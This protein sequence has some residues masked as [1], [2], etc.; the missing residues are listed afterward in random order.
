[1]R[2]DNI[3]TVL[4]KNATIDYLA[5]LELKG[6]SYIVVD[7][8][9]DLR[10]ILT[11]IKR[12]FNVKTISLQGGG[13]IDGAMLAQGLINELSLVIYPGIDGLSTAPSILNTSDTRKNV[14]PRD[15]LWS[16][17]RWSKCLMALSGYATNSIIYLNNQS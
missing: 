7:D 17:S 5:Y 9:R 6:I 12:H 1:M 16:F 4:G 11:L 10:N 8:I 2:G 3:L 15:R 14:R 13:I